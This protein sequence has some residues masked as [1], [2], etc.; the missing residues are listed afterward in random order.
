MILQL[1]NS[2]LMLVPDTKLDK[3]DNQKWLEA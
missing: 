2:Q 3:N 1:Q